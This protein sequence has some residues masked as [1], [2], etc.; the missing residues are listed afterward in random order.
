[1]CGSDEPHTYPVRSFIYRTWQ[2]RAK[3]VQ[4][5]F[6]YTAY[7]MSVKLKLYIL[8]HVVNICF[9]FVININMINGG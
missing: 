4:M 5:E 1:M 9:F 2:A 3:Q 7:F 6:V 8:I